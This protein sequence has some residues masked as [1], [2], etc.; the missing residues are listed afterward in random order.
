MLDTIMTVQ[1]AHG[2]LLADVLTELQALRAELASFRRSPLPPPFD[3][4]S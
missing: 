1:A 3:D 4:E 2:K